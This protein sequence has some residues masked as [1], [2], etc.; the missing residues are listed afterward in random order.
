MENTES[1]IKNE[2]PREAC[3]IEYTRRKVGM[4]SCEEMLS[5]Y[6]NKTKLNYQGELLWI[7][8]YNW[9][10]HP[11]LTWELYM[12]LTTLIIDHNVTLFSAME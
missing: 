11:L 10:S 12:V 5:L 2:Q 3:N 1:A 8:Q 7:S 9:W 4:Q 6:N